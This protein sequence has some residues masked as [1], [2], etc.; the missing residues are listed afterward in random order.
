[1]RSAVEQLVNVLI[2][3]GKADQIEKVLSE[4][5]IHPCVIREF[6]TEPKR[7]EAMAQRMKAA[8]DRKAASKFGAKGTAYRRI[9]HTKIVPEPGSSLSELYKSLG[10]P[11]REHSFHATKGWRSHRVVV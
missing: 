7:R 8:R 2:R 4:H 10:T 9:I 6:A 5:D 3:S 11:S 1:M